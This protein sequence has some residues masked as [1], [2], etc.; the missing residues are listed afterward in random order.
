MVC[1]RGRHDTSHEIHKLGHIL[2]VNMCAASVPYSK[3][4]LNEKDVPG[5]ILL[6]YFADIISDIYISKIFSNC[7]DF[8]LK[9][10]RYI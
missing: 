10:M 8:V 1:K 3:I 9:K 4:S 5:A 6:I 7:T 2:V